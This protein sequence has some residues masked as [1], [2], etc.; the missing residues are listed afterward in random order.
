MYE[1]EQPLM[2]DVGVLALAPDPWGDHWMVRHNVLAR[3]A[4]YFYVVWVNPASRW[5]EII[6][7]RRQPNQ[8]PP[9][10][11]DLPG[12]VAFQPPPWLPELYR[13]R[14]L[15]QLCFDQRLKRARNLLVKRGCRRIVLY[16]WRPE[17]E[18][19]LRSVAHDLSCYHLED[20]YSFSNVEVPLDPSEARLIEAVN[21]VFVLSPGLLRKRA[22]SIPVPPSSPEAL[23][24]IPTQTHRRSRQIWHAFPDPASV[25]RVTSRSSSIGNSSGI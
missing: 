11:P 8:P 5:R 2:A 13:P 10:K 9:M 12:F 25:T 14:W 3:L 4:H 21:Q 18:R 20:E 7:G 16:L 17:F 1:S 6:S 24:T 15:A 19:A 23:T 22:T